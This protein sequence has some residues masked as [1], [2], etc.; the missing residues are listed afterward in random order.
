MQQREGGTRRRLAGRGSG[1]SAIVAAVL[2]SV[3][4][5][6]AQADAAGY[7][8]GPTPIIGRR[9][10]T[11][12]TGSVTFFGRG[13]GHGVGMSQYGAR[14]RADAGQTMATIL[15]HYYKG[16]TI[17][18]LS[19]TVPPTI[20]L[21]RVLVLDK[22]PATAAVPLTIHGRSANWT[23]S[24]T[25]KTFAK[26]AVLR[27]IPTVTTVPAGVSVA[28]RLRI[29]A[30]NGD[31]Q[32]DAASTASFV[33]GPGDDATRLRLDS[34]PSSFDTYRGTLKVIFGSTSAAVTV[35]N[36]L[37][38]ESY[39][40]GVVPSEMP[41][42]WNPE[43]LKCQAVVAR[44]YAARRIKPTVGTFDVKDDTSSQVYLGVENEKPA[45][46]TAISAT[47]NKVVKSGTAIADALFHST[48]GTA[49]ENN[50]NVFVSA[51]GE[52]TNSPV[53]Y[54]RGSSDRAPNGT[55]YD[56][57]SPWLHWNTATYTV[58]QLSAWLASDPQ[59]SVGTL[60]AIDLHNR[61]VSGRL[62][63]VTLIG[64]GGTKTVSGTVFR[65]VFNDNRPPADPI[66]RSNAF[67][68]TPFP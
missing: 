37:P 61:G 21:I 18:D 1:T 17:G 34:K 25:G 36:S 31:V 12:V 9:G 32:Y 24:G 35:V 58:D 65:T 27:L 33:V 20:P 68:L 38:L 39:L 22:F 5:G 62:I 10:P 66:L 41:A 15:A 14:G 67:A 54:L 63:S 43:A 45:T 51:T 29:V 23:V 26:D 48:G 47:A 2:V 4:L 40:K 16:T 55:P 46:T 28:W 3:I 42:T 59:T 56:S 13:F 19:P 49:T 44:G 64:T 60:T 30:P 53:S 7:V 6:T 52:I 50:E 57:S 8:P 11:P